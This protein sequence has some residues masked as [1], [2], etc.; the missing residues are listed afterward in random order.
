M[1]LAAI[2]YEL[3]RRKLLVVLALIPAVAV[4]L[5]LAY[6]VSVNPPKLRDKGFSA[7][8]ASVQFIVDSERSSLGTI[9]Q[10]AKVKKDEPVQA[11]PTDPIVTKALVFRA[12]TLARVA[13][14]DEILDRVAKRAGIPR[15]QLTATPPS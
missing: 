14:S 3:R 6:R 10:P 5:A 11:T 12:Q 13:S 9:P 8:A 2:F 4:G 7:G 1:D 15:E